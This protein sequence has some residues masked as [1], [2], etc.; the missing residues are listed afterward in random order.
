MRRLHIHTYQGIVQYNVR[1]GV[2][3]HLIYLDISIVIAYNNRVLKVLKLSRRDRQ[4]DS[5]VEEIL[6]WIAI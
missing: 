2:K 1:S 6:R 4:I 3:T 5:L